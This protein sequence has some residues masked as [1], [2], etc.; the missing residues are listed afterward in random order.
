VNAHRPRDILDGT[1]SNAAE[2]CG[3]L[4]RICTRTAR[5]RDAANSAI[6]VLSIEAPPE[7]IV[8]TG[9]LPETA[10]I[11]CCAAVGRLTNIRNNVA[12]ADP[13]RLVREVFG[14]RKMSSEYLQLTRGLYDVISQTCRIVAYP[15][16]ERGAHLREPLQTE[17]IKTR[18]FGYSV[19]MN[20]QTA[21]VQ[22]R[23]LDPAEVDAIA[24][25]P[26]HGAYIGVL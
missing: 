8:L 9:I 6:G 4:S 22:Y 24:C 13:E 1:F 25:S 10:M 21:I 17:K 19:S 16:Q 26:D 15:G 18:H 23:K 11:D 20:R 12:G 5:R 7:P 14:F 2:T 3:S